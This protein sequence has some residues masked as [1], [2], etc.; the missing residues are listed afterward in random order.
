MTALPLP[1]RQTDSLC[2][3]RAADHQG[4]SPTRL[5]TALAAAA[6]GLFISMVAMN[7][8]AA[9]TAAKAAAAPASS[10]S[11]QSRYKQERAM[12]LP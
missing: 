8:E 4:L 7:S 3:Q 2:Q 6:V 5:V 12:H 11:A 1:A 10:S 9:G